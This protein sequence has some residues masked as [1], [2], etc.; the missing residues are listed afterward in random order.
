M[1]IRRRCPVCGKKLGLGSILLPGIKGGNERVFCQACGN[2]VSPPMRRY[3]WIGFLGLPFGI[4][5][6]KIPDYLGV[7]C[8]AWCDVSITA[9]VIFSFILAVYYLIPLNNQ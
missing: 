8:G 6:G 3:N 4:L 2:H 5:V 7:V 1:R 9:L